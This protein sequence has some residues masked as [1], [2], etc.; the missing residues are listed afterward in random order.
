MT[1]NIFA[2]RYSIQQRDKTITSYKKLAKDKVTKEI[3]TTAFGKQ[4]ENIAQGHAKN[5]GTAGMD[6]IRVMN[7]KQIMNILADRVVTY[8]R[9]VGR[10][11]RVRITARGNII[12]S[13]QINH[14]N[15]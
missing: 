5:R 2:P 10:S 1:S 8:A 4:F 9:V 11:E 6:T 12:A 13:R 14:K 7:L 3:W 15:S